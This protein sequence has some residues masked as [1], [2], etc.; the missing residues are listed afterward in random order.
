MTEQG[1]YIKKEIPDRWW[2]IAFLD[3]K[4][5]SDFEKIFG[6]ILATGA[7]KE[8]ALNAVA[9]LR[10]ENTGYILTDTTRKTSIIII[11]H[12]TSFDEFFDTVTHEMQHLTAAICDFY[13]YSHT[14]EKAAYLQGEI[15]KNLYKAVALSIC[16]KCNCNEKRALTRRY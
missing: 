12:A 6:T 7:G 14:G 2:V 9:E 16:P 10:N 1:F 5:D 13:N 11:S 4:T 3:A 15:G 8:R